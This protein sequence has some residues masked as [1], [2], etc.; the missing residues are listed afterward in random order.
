MNPYQTLKSPILNDAGLNCHAV[1]AIENLSPEV[2]A[3]LF[4]RCPQAK[5]YSQLILI[6]HAGTQLWRSL[7]SNVADV[8]EK[9]NPIDTYT[10]DVVQRFLKTEHPS[11]A[12]EIVYPGT[13]TVSL[14]E[15]GKLA[16]WHHASPFMVG[17]NAHV[18]SWF[19]YRALV[20]ANTDL[21]VTTAL[22]SESPCVTCEDSPCISACPA[23]AL[24]DGKFHLEKCL[25]YRQ[26]SDSLCANTCLARCA[27]PVGS[28]HRYSDA[29]MQFH[30]GRSMKMIR[31]Y[32]NNKQ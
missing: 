30:Y 16:A 24:D 28:E 17:I 3:A 10:I 20:L 4:A 23:H 22:V 21:A 32:A 12:Y 11:A 26:Q 31:L 13:D 1:F 18:G 7:N 25:S 27:C 19:A 9:A 8:S 5:N 6:A 2:K 29:Q 15:L 14:Q